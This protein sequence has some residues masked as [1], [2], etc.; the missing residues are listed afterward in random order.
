MSP[1]NDNDA[2][3]ALELQKELDEQDSC[4]AVEPITN[5]PHL[6]TSTTSHPVHIH[7]HCQACDDTIENWQCLTC[8]TVLCS[9]YRQAHMQDHVKDSGHFVCLS[10]AD[11]SVW[12]F[13]CDSYVTHQVNETTR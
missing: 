13:A 3:L 7:Q 12:C 4:F 9:R 1:Q 11:L 5:C 10:Y 2:A 8:D 6:P